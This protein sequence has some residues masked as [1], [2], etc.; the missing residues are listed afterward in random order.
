MNF[1]SSPF[2]GNWETN[3]CSAGTEKNRVL[4]MRLPSPSPVQDKNWASKGPKELSL[5]ETKHG[6]S[7]ENSGK[8]RRIF[9]CDIQELSFAAVLREQ[10]RHIRKKHIKFLK[11]PWTAGC[12]WNTRPDR[13][14]G[15]KKTLSCQIFYSKQQEVP[16]TPAGGP[17]VCPAP[18]VSGTPGRCPEDS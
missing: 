8:L 15:K 16:G 11:I 7:S 10:N 12:P 13:C 4:P 2:Q 14:P 5:Q 18:G 9:R 1:Q 17:P 3:L 6:K